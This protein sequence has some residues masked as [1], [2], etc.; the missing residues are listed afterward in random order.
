MRQP[1]GTYYTP[2]DVADEMVKDALAAAVRDYT[3]SEVA[4]G[5]LLD[6]FG[7]ADEPLLQ[8]T[9]QQRDRLLQRI[10]K[11]RIFDP[12]VGSGEFLFSMLTALQ[13]AIRKLDSDHQVAAA[14]IIE[15]Q[16]F[17]QDINP[18]AVQIARLRLFI[19]IIADRAPGVSP[20]PPPPRVTPTQ[21][22]P[23]P[24][25]EARIV[26]ADTLQTVA[27]PNWRPE[28]PGQLAAADPA[29]AAA[30]TAVAENRAR[31]FDAHTE[32]AKQQVLTRD[33]QLRDRLNWLL[34]GNADLANPELL[35]F[36]EAELLSNDP[37]PTPHRRPPAVL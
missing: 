18:L 17:G 25:L 34:Q 35:G 32:D 36:A 20:P 1:Q 24:N 15:G 30:L 14:D 33:T 12:A 4:D 31:W 13:R 16:L 26:C 7:A 28:H 29:L 6:L 21:N 8:L 37:V 23:L 19:A 2:A 3:P 5:Q 22:P 10:K 27:D 9:E 11:L